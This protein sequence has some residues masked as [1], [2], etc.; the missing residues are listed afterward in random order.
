MTEKS[1]CYFELLNQLSLFHKERCGT[2]HNLE[3]LMRHDEYFLHQ[4]QSCN[5]RLI[6][7]GYEQ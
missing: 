3:A 1:E 4:V 5:D 7:Q 2:G 6:A